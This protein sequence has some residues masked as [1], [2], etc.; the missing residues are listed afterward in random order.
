MF[1]EAQCL[2]LLNLG[3]LVVLQAMD[4]DSLGLEVGRRVG[5]SGGR[6]RGCWPHQMRDSLITCSTAQFVAIF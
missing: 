5:G 4:W 1:V 2:L 6:Y 3:T